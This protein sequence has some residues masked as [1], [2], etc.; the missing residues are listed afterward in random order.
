MHKAN[1]P[2]ETLSAT[3]Q[4]HDQIAWHS[5][6]AMIS[7]AATVKL[8]HLS[9]SRKLSQR[10]GRGGGHLLSFSEDLSH[11]CYIRIPKSS[12]LFVISSA[13]V[14]MLLLDL[15]FYCFVYSWLF[16]SSVSA[17]GFRYSASWEERQTEVGSNGV[18]NSR[19]ARKKMSPSSSVQIT[20]M[21]RKK[22]IEK[23]IPKKIH[24]QSN[25]QH[26]VNSRHRMGGST[27]AR[28][29]GYLNS[30]N[31]IGY[32]HCVSITKA[33]GPGRLFVGNEFDW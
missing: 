16:F 28:Q 6:N 4:N 26:S 33:Q 31:A 15:Y 8:S 22:K 9:K 5:K 2:L 27:H 17:N 25:T 12:Q 32:C 24:E 29:Y 1:Q 30:S 21:E 19:L 14:L 18:G 23:K 10:T 3:N 7:N 13:P 11:C 20:D